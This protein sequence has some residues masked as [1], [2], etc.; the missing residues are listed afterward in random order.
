MHKK[1]IE[2]QYG[3]DIGIVRER[4]AMHGTGKFR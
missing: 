1:E 4:E 3:R 2:I